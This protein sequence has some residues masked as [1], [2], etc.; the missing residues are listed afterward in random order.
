MCIFFI[1]D[2]YIATG[3]KDKTINIYSVDGQKITSLRGHAASICCLS[4]IRTLNNDKF[5]ASG[6]DHGCSS[7]ILWDTKTWNMQTKVACHTA[8][9]T[10]IVDLD[11][12]RHLVTGSYDK[13]INLF[14]HAKGKSITT[15]SNNKTSVTSMVM[16]SD[17]MR[18]VSSGLDSSLSVWTIVRKNDVILFIYSGRL[19]HRTINKHP[20]R[21]IS[22]STTAMHLET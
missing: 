6:S 2:K 15:L 11:D 19:I 16:T 5:L 18:L 12:G 4:M 20:Q 1:N 22:L 7:L 17:K 21:L 13:K 8:A 3:S 9:V 14:N 10:A